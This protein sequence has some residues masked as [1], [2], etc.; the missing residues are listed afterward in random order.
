[1]FDLMFLPQKLTAVGIVFIINGQLEDPAQVEGQP[2][3]AEDQHQA[4]HC[5]CHLTSLNR[6]ANRYH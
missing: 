1:M 6:S 2:A 5:L 4:E 3:E